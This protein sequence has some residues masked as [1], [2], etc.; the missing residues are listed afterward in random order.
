MYYA[1]FAKNPTLDS[2]S[3]TTGSVSAN[4]TLTIPIVIKGFHELLKAVLSVVITEYDYNDYD[5][6]HVNESDSIVVELFY[7]KTCVDFSFRTYLPQTVT[8]YILPKFQFNYN[9]IDLSQEVVYGG[10]SISWNFRARYWETLTITNHAN[11]LNQETHSELAKAL[12][13]VTEPPSDTSLDAEMHRI[14]TNNDGEWLYWKTVTVPL[15]WEI[16]SG[17]TES[18]KYGFRNKAANDLLRVHV[19]FLHV[20]IF[21]KSFSDNFGSKLQN[22]WFLGLSNSSFFH[23]PEDIK[24]AYINVAPE[25]ALGTVDDWSRIWPVA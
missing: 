9:S 1:N 17:T 20:R 23:D 10:A 11:L 2:A 5:A 13:S 6:V 16:V 22:I 25:N 24:E 21:S 4:K 7:S 8:Y 18:F 3:Y 19:P 12:S 15:N 14:V